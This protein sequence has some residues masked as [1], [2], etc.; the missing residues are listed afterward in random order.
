MN[1]KGWDIISLTPI[2]NVNQ[3]LS[4]HWIDLHFRKNEGDIE[5]QGTFGTWTFVPGG[6]GKILRVSCPIL[7]GRLHVF[8][9]ELKL[10]GMTAV[11]NLMLNFFDRARFTGKYGT[12][13]QLDLMFDL[14]VPQ[15]IT[16]CG[17]LQNNSDEELG[18]MVQ[19]VDLLECTS[20]YKYT[21]LNLMTDYIIENAAKLQTVFASVILHSAQGSWLSPAVCR[22]AF[23][24]GENPYLAILA[25]CTNRDISD[26]PLDV[27]VVDLDLSGQRSYY[28]VSKALFAKNTGLS[29][30]TSLFRSSS[31]DYSLCEEVLN[32]KCRVFMPKITVGAIDYEPYVESES[33]RFWISGSSLKVDLDRGNCDLYAGINMSWCS[34]NTFSCSYREKALVFTKTESVFRHNEDIPWYLRFIPL[35]FIIDI[36]V[37]CISDSLAS[38]IAV[39]VDIE[40]AVLSDI[41]WY[42]AGAEIKDAFLKEGFVISF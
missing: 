3:T 13:N 20:V 24:D 12:E 23:L 10:D 32:N 17:N 4:D 30:F 21:V 25:V 15:Y 34:Y 14:R 41:R 7:E 16:E 37:G 19:P 35:S 2:Q 27:D 39:K 26:L 29:C 9:T 40:K 8:G 42:G 33:A 18:G 22:Y 6:S 38:S 11:F 36:C 31:D 1:L 28:A 5:L